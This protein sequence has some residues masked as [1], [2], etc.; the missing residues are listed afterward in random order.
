MRCLSVNQY[1]VP[2][3]SNKYIFNKS[4]KGHCVIVIDTETYQFEVCFPLWTNDHACLSLWGLS[5]AFSLRI[6]SHHVCAV[7][8]L[9]S[10]ECGLSI[11]ALKLSCRLHLVQVAVENNT[12]SLFFFLLNE[13]RELGLEF[14]SLLGH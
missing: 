5:F 3:T 4:T 13:N 1:S 2:F 10:D 9:P 12:K 14:K 8:L 11:C 7:T 6:L